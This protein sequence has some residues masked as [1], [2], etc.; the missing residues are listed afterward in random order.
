[1]AQTLNLT[2]GR[3]KYTA[4]QPKQTSYGM[5]IN[6]VLTLASGEEVKLWGDPGDPALTALTKGQQVQLAQNS[7]GNW[8]LVHQ[9]QQSQEAP[10]Q[11][12]G[13]GVIHTEWTPDEKRALASSIE[14]RAKLMRLCLE[15]AR[16][17]CGD[18][19]E[20]SEDLRA[21]AIVLFAEALKKIKKNY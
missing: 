1:M 5:R 15:Q 9:Q 20:S 17:H 14:E 21:V 3:V 13:N 2:Y 10:H 12:N 16:K 11:D 18:Y 7:K 4:G 6:V 19:L 8:Q